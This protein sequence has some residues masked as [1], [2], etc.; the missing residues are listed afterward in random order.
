MNPAEAAQALLE[1]TFQ[2]LGVAHAQ[3]ESAARLLLGSRNMQSV[4][5][6]NEPIP[7][8]AEVID[9]SHTQAFLA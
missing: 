6:G 2:T 4:A 7:G 1:T 9:L 3:C 8:N 5:N